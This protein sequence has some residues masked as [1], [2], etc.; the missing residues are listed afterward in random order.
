VQRL[1]LVI[2]GHLGKD[3]GATATLKSDGDGSP[4]FT[5][6]LQ[7]ERWINLQQA[8]SFCIAHK[9]SSLKTELKVMLVVPNN[10]KL[11]IFDKGMIDVY[12][13]KK[14][15]FGLE[16][17]VKLANDLNADVIEFHNNSAPFAADGFETLCFAKT[18][19][20][21]S[22]SEGFRIAESILNQAGALVGCKKRSVKPIYSHELKKFID[23]EIYII[24]NVKNNCVITEAGFMSSNKDLTNIDVDL[25]GYNEQ[26]GAAIWSGYE[27]VYKQIVGVS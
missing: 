7:E 26:I 24:K 12:D 19:P 16:D 4:S 13:F 22:L 20:S 23:R 15:Y 8:I 3:V 5:S 27:A 18:D 21:G 1:L 9:M 11:K 2:P 14:D 10:Q 25:D 17:R 6:V